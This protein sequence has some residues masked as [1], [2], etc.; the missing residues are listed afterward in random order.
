VLLTGIHLMATGETEANLERLLE[1]RQDLRDV[2]ELLLAK[3]SG[4]ERATLAE[5][6]LD[7]HSERYLALRAELERAY[8]TSTLPDRPTARRDIDRLVIGTRLELGPARMAP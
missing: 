5:A 3:R 1:E 6:D 4:S 2:L 7:R 8:E